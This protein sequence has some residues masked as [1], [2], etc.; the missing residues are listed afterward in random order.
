MLH[1]VEILT[2]DPNAIHRFGEPLVIKFWIRH[3]V[4]MIDGTFCFQIYNQFQVPVIHS[5]YYQ[6]TT[7]G[8]TPGCSVFM[9][10]FPR[11]LLN[12]GQF[13]LR[14]W[15]QSGG[16]DIYESLDGICAFEVIRIDKTQFLGWRSE[17]CTYHEDHDW[18]AV[19][20]TSDMSEVA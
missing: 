19:N 17:I 13:H 1:R 20:V 11:L 2:S 7:L 3:P 12:V 10:R 9:C 6:E 15:L 4:P 16:V 18:T 5:S 14:T 8:D